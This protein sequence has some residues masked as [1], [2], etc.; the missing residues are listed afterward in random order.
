[1][2]TAPVSTQENNRQAGMPK[3]MVLDP[4]WFDRDRRKF[5]D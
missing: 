4:E 1:M 2:S 3:N 5:E